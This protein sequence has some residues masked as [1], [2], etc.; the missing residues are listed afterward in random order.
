[1]PEPIED[2]CVMNTFECLE[3][4]PEAEPQK[5]HAWCAE[6][7]G[8]ACMRLLETYQQQAED[9]VQ[10]IHVAQGRDAGAILGNA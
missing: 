4:L 6:G 9:A 10:F 7:V 8:P 2:G 5:L 1:M 3:A